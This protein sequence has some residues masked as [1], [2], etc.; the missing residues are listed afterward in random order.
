MSTTVNALTKVVTINSLKA[1]KAEGEKISC[2]ALYDA[3][4][5]AL[6][7]NAGVETIIVG[8]SLGM[9][10]Q[11]YDSTVPVTIEHMIYHTAAVSRGNRHSLIIADLPFMAYATIEQA[12]ANATLLMQAGA[13]MIKIEGGSWLCATV[14]KLSERGIPVC[15][16][17]GLTP[18][19][20][21]KLG[22]YRIQGRDDQQAQQIISDV[23]ALQEAGAD[24]LVLECIPSSLTKVIAEQ[25]QVIT[26]GIGAG[27][28]TDGQVLVINDLL[29][30]TQKPPKFSKNYLTGNH[31]IEAAMKAFVF[32]IKSG[33]FPTDK[34]CFS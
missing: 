14:T 3:Q 26:I 15:C 34:H 12:M 33:D 18:Q 23:K 29:G 4:M 25:T 9:T 5:A 10:V 6:A 17:L 31:S 1:L 22:G 32:E 24:L 28:A 7:A 27:P 20:I 30:M 2:V 16:H 19:S 8:D 13:H 21:N 11:G